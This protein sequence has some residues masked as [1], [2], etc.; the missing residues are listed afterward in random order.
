MSNDYIIAH[1]EWDD[2]GRKA[3]KV[4][5]LNFFFANNTAFT[6]IDELSALL[7][8]FNHF[9]YSFKFHLDN[10]DDI[11]KVYKIIDPAHF[12]HYLV[13]INV[14]LYNSANYVTQ[15]EKKIRQYDAN[16]M[17]NIANSYA[18]TNKANFRKVTYVDINSYKFQTSPKED[19]IDPVTSRL[20]TSALK[21][22]G[23]DVCPKCGSPGSFIRMA[24]VCKD[25]G[26]F[27][28]C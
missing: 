27:G 24:L 5:D 3:K 1:C 18:K 28:G 15:V 14:L 19:G 6:E 25:H 23:R 13:P 4:T 21:T 16:M 7:T 11:T 26:T 8:S 22:H 2:I 20:M 9:N 17:F 12:N 10:W